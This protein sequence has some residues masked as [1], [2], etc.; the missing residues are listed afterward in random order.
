M[1]AELSTLY[2]ISFTRPRLDPTRD[3][4]F[5]VYFVLESN[6]AETFVTDLA[7]FIRG[8]GQNLIHWS[9]LGRPNCLGPDDPAHPVLRD[10]A[11][12]WD[13]VACG[14]GVVQFSAS[15]VSV[16]NI[17]R[18]FHR[19]SR[20]VGAVCQT[21]RY[22]YFASGTFLDMARMVLPLVFIEMEAA[23]QYV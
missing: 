8:L 17:Q 23:A 9:V 3:G 14:H 6:G 15:N 10:I 20:I 5:C 16:M 19:M 11:Y 12:S 21:H 18:V 2:T 7:L 1:E 22:E 4:D 13:G